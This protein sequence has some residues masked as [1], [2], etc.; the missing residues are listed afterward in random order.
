VVIVVVDG[1]ETLTKEDDEIIKRCKAKKFLLVI[2]KADLL[3]VIDEKELASLAPDVMP[4]LWISAKHG[5]GITALTDAIHGL[6][7][8]GADYGRTLNIVSNIR[9]K[10]ALEK[11]RDMLSKARDSML[12]GLSPEF[13]AFDIRQALERLGEIAGE[14][15]TEEVL[16][17]IFAT[18]CIG[19]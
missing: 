14:T 9:H 1:S 4:P 3:H 17:K 5:D 8:N 7:L 11:T 15:A 2:N 16:E 18:F 13:P 6:A 19:K 12:Q 10:M